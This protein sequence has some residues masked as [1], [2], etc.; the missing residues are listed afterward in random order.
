M[1]F[2]FL[3]LSWS[4]KPPMSRLPATPPQLSRLRNVKRNSTEA[5]S[6]AGMLIKF[7]QFSSSL[8]AISSP[9]PSQASAG[10][11]RSRRNR[12]SHPQTV[13]AN[14]TQTGRQF[15]REHVAHNVNS[16]I[17]PL[18]SRANNPRT[19]FQ[20]LIIKD[21]S[22]LQVHKCADRMTADRDGSGQPGSVS[23]AST[24]SAAL[25]SAARSQLHFYN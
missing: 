14:D 18:Q 13:D 4:Q 20:K 19:T 11:E 16:A 2:A 12:E 15:G 3:A 24:S 5:E 6:G 10:G 1:S 7:T 9:S 23:E 25:L 22:G 21:V 17:R 8:E